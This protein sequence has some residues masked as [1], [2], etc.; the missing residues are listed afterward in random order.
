MK[1]IVSQSVPDL[2]MMPFLLECMLD[3]DRVD[4]RWNDQRENSST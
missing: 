3:S 4:E 2:A 1:L